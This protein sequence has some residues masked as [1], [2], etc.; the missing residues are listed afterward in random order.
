M[1]EMQ[2]RVFVPGGL[3]YNLFVPQL[4]INEFLPQIME[5]NQA[6]LYESKAR[7]VENTPGQDKVFIWIKSPH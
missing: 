7:F 6:V 4:H 2:S 1:D 3:H 5:M